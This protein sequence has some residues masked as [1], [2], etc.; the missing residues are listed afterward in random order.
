MVTQNEKNFFGSYLYWGIILQ[1]LEFGHII[2]L[3]LMLAAVTT[4]CITPC[5]N[6]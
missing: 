4:Y 1:P 3:G 5:N 6:E 2:V